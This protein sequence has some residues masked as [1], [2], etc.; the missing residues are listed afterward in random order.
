MINAIVIELVAVKPKKNISDC[1][2][3]Q[4]NKN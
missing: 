2:Q 4:I 3:G 1:L